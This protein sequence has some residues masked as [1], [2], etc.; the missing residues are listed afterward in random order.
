[1]LQHQW[2]CCYSSY[3]TWH[4]FNTNLSPHMLDIFITSQNCFKRI[5][6]CKTVNNGTINN[7][8]ATALYLSITSINFVP[9]KAKEI[10]WE[11]FYMM[12]KQTKNSTIYWH[13]QYIINTHYFMTNLTNPLSDVHNPPPPNQTKNVKDGSTSARIH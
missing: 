6:D 5:C 4:L 3:V 12:K 13:N 1:M 10:D 7:H 8:S 2:Y 9:P 11:K